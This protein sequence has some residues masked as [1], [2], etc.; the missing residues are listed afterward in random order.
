MQRLI[1]FLVLAFSAH[2]VLPV[3]EAGV[4]AGQ[5]AGVT[6][7][8]E[9]G[10]SGAGTGVPGSSDTDGPVPPGR[11]VTAPSTEPEQE[12]AANEAGARARTDA[13][14]QDLAAAGESEDEA[15]AAA[16]TPDAP[17]PRPGNSPSATSHRGTATGT[18]PAPAPA[19]AAAGGALSW[20]PPAGWAG[21]PVTR[22]TATNSV[23]T[24]SG[25]GGDVLVQ[26]PP[27]RAVAP[28]II[29]NC[30]N[31]VVM[32]GR[33]DV[34]PTARPDGNDQRAIYVHKCTGTVH[35]EGVL[36]NGNVSGSQADGIAV[37]A[38][39]ALVQIQNVRMEGLRGTYSVNHADVFQ[40]WGGV[41]EFRIDR[42][43]GSTN[44]QGIQ[45]RR[46]LGAIGRGTIRNANVSSSGVTPTDRGGQFIRVECN[47]YPLAL[48]NVYVAGREGRSFGTSVWPQ[49][50][51]RSC[52]AV[53]QGGVASWPSASNIAG[54]VRQGSPAAGD[55]VPAG[56]VGL[57]YVSPGYR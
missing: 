14:A 18:A 42:L 26:L 44:Y 12:Q 23:T 17:A 50:D 48:D 13:R 20:A 25:K 43:T 19:P 38:P 45:V 40:P 56:T 24:V 53:I 51:D 30:R 36:I 9:G 1:A 7:S 10:S 27:D 52:P 54:G 32:G 15:P 3:Q 8:P 57:G 11:P 28:I 22:I 16:T 47:G 21:Y 5:E 35:I 33:I 6:G 41:R 31:A 34:L 46:D 39:D 29:A 49:S 2:Q 37:N 4:V 55:F